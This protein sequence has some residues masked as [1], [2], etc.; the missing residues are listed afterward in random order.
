MGGAGRP[1]TARHRGRS[2]QRRIGK[3]RGDDPNVPL[4]SAATSREATT[5]RVSGMGAGLVIGG[6]GA[7][8]MRPAEGFGHSG[9]GGSTA[10]ADPTHRFSFALVE[11][12]M[13]MHGLNG[14]LAREIRTALGIA[15]D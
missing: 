10:F 5:E 7:K 3:G 6:N 9:S 4:L 1:A 12:R 14:R 8:P 15:S 2:R 13:T 11:N